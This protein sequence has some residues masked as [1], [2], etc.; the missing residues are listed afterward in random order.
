MIIDDHP[1]MREAVS[2]LL[3]ELRP[4]VQLLLAGTLTEAQ[5][6]LAEQLAL[7]A[8]VLDLKLPDGDC[9]PLVRRLRQQFGPQLRMFVLSA[10]MQSADARRML[11]A[12]ANGY[13][14]KGESHKT[15]ASA[16]RLV[17]EGGDYLPPLLLDHARAQPGR[18]TGLTARQE[19]VL[20]RL[21]SGLS[22]K[23]IADEL[24]IAERTVKLHVQALFELLGA[25]NRTHA[26]TRAR[27][28]GLLD[29]AQSLN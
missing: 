25:N 27:Q 21:A 20:A 23:A 2:S 6:I 22:N 15:M 13:C 7:D 12:G 8:A 19:Q 3:R 5:H 17:L 4:Q 26:V 14:S 28:A 16:L 11:Q 1:L 10:S 29:A 24:D 9:E 18:A